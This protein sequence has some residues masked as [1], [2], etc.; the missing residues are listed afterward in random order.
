MNPIEEWPSFVHTRSFDNDWEELGLD[1]EDLARLQNAI[2]ANPEAGA[3]VAGAGGLRK[4]R[5]AR[6]GEGKSGSVRV[7][8][9]NIPNHG[10]VIL[11]LVYGKAVKGDL[12][13]HEKRFFR[14][15]LDQYK[16]ELDAE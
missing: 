9:A 2:V 13:P 11:A 16:A 6:P 10:I 3:V 8:Y 4:L 14:D 7:C 15:L 12:N 5:F 1:D